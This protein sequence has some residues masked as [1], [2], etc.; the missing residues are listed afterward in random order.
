MGVSMNESEAKPGQREHDAP[1]KED[2]CKRIRESLFD[3]PPVY[4]LVSA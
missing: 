4:V 2:D 3:P 1:D